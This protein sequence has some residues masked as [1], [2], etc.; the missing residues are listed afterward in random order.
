MPPSTAG[1]RP[2]ATFQTGPRKGLAKPSRK[3]KVDASED[4]IRLRRNSVSQLNTNRH[5]KRHKL[6]IL[7]TGLV[8][9]VSVY[10][11]SFASWW[12]RGPSYAVTVM[13]GKPARC[14]EL[15]MTPF[16]WRTLYLWYPAILYMKHVCGYKDGDTIAAAE[17]SGYSFIK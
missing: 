16:R 5:M 2:A 9:L 6:L 1:Q 4:Q 12:N 3:T 15:H 11:W 8:L 13:N 14:V 10:I 7:C 17:D